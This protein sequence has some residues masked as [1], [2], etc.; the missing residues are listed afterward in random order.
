MK[1]GGSQAIDD[2]FDFQ[3]SVAEIE[4]QAQ[5]PAGGLQVIEA[6]GAM[7]LIQCLRGFQLDQKR[8]L[9]QQVRDV[10]PDRLTIVQDR[11]GVL[12]R[13]G[14]SGLAH[15]V[16][17]RILIDLL[18]EAGAERIE[19]GERAADDDPGQRIQ[20]VFI[21]VH[22]RESSGICVMTSLSRLPTSDCQ[23]IDATSAPPP[24]CHAV[25][26]RLCWADRAP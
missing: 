24:P 7:R 3:T 15:L 17:Q 18:H 8:L 26:L 19:H 1:K 11:D 4:Q 5:G 6:L 2:A 25:R 10:L 22:L 9:D 23:S 16:G 13:D 12:L 21:R 14:K 20:A